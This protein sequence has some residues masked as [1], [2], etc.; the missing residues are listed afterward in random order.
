MSDIQKANIKKLDVG[1]LSALEVLLRERSV[2]RAAS[3]AG[4][5]QPA[6]SNALARI[7]IAFDDALLVR[8]R[9]GM[10]LTE[11][12]QALLDQLTVLTPQLERLGRT[13]GFDPLTSEMTFF[14]AGTDHANFVLMPEIMRLFSAEAPLATLK[15]TTVLS[16]EADLDRLEAGGYD[17]RVGWFAALPPH[18]RKR[19]L[20]REEL[21]MMAR[22]DHPC[23]AP[24]L[25]LDTFLDFKHLVLA[26]D[27]RSTRNLVDDVL[28]SMGLKR[29]VGAF[30]S[31]FGA[32]ALMVAACDL[33]AILPGRL[34]RRFAFLPVRIRPSPV[35][36][37]DFE[38]VLAWHPR[39][40]SDAAYVWLRDLIV[41]AAVSCDDNS[42]PQ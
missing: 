39:V 17:V 35:A 19:T 37:K 25:G 12:G 14:V 20:L 18:W 31:S 8:G 5:S 10:M 23:F 1:L 7:R 40:H 30:V 24:D 26:P 6:M 41:R 34:A 32:M 9:K 2:S 22:A 11:G 33:V 3:H 29:R 4:L 38:M 21:V 42:L 27:K 13:P 28:A 16:R 36:F 15:L